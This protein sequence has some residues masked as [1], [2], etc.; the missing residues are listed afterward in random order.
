MDGQ[1]GQ[2]LAEQAVI[3]EMRASAMQA[4]SKGNLALATQLESWA[5]RL[6]TAT[7]YQRPSAYPYPLTYSVQFHPARAFVPVF[8]GRQLFRTRFR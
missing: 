8:G 5:V 3:A 2:G 6:E 4:R 1:L 7:V